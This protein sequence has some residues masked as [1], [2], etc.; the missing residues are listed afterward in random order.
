[1]L[2][3]TFSVTFKHR[4]TDWNTLDFAKSWGFLQSI[5]K[6]AAPVKVCEKGHDIDA[7]VLF[8]I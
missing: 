7:D 3:E 4:E 5:L 8:R 2:N 1:M 6:A